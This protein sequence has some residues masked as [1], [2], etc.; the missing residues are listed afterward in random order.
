MHLFQK[1]WIYLK[2][3]YFVIYYKCLY[4]DIWSF[5]CILTEYK[6][7][8]SYLSYCNILNSSVYII[9]LNHIFTHII[10]HSSVDLFSVIVIMLSTFTH[11]LKS[12]WLKSKGNALFKLRVKCCA[13]AGHA[14]TTVVNISHIIR[15]HTSHISALQADKLVWMVWSLRV[16][17]HL[18]ETKCMSSESLICLLKLV[19]HVRMKHIF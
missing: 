7:I 19:N 8:N 10:V 17:C 1:S 6:K 16:C 15:L 13:H 5:K 18:V 3:N 14:N 12:V 11:V 2:Y 4:C 9:V